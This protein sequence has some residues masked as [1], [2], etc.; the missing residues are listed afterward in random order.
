MSI[1]RLT[2]V[3]I[4]NVDVSN[5]VLNWN[6]EREFDDDISSITIYLNRNVNNAIVLS[7]NNIGDKLIVKRGA[8]TGSETTI[9]IGEVR[10]VDPSGAVVVIKGSDRL[11]EARRAMVTKSFDKNI[12]S[13]AG[14]FSEI[15]KTLINDYTTLTADNTS[16]QDSGTTLTIN[17]FICNNADVFER[18]AELAETINW[19]FYYNPQ[20][21]KVYFEPKGFINTSTTFAVGDNIIGVPSWTF[22][23]SDLVNHLK[24]VGAE[25]EV[26]TTEL[27]SGDNSKTEFILKY[28]PVSV[29]VYV[30]G[31]LKVGGR[32]GSTSGSYDYEVDSDNKKIIFKSAPPSATNNIEVSY[33]YM[34]PAPVVGKRQTSIDTFGEYQKTI[35]KN[36]LKTIEDA[37][38]YMNKYLDQYSFP[39]INAKIRVIS[40]TDA[41]P[42]ERIVVVDDVNGV[43][44]QLLVIKVTMQY[45]YKYDE[46]EVGD[47]ILKTSDWMAGI[48]DR[49]RRLEER[50]GQSTDLLLHVIDSFRES[51]SV[52]R[53]YVKVNWRSV[54]GSN[55]VIGNS[56]FG[57]L[58]DAII[59]AINNDFVTIRLIPGDKDFKEYLYDY[60][61]I[62]T[63][64]SDATVN[65]I[66]NTV[67]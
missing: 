15:F 30:G 52:E 41:N 26:E 66:T 17:K 55:L 47:K 1:P 32:E 7:V 54:S 49:V 60:E 3:A 25:Q 9:F 43:N 13:E 24:I 10:E 28:K 38:A 16:V 23:S 64:V 8:V 37:K 63:S 14:K 65:I 2:Y 35:F 46:I 18:I 40:A 31:V 45:P 56:S 4:N 53:R 57:I 19:Q 50:A 6:Y 39:F 36:E 20:T 22:E 67:S 42:G 59:G 12:D 21:D 29:K 33:S 27:F 61:F 5:Y 51:V 48:N 11:F 58:G 62:D 44:Q 34:L